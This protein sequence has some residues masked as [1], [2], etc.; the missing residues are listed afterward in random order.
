M[1]HVKLKYRNDMEQLY[2]YILLIATLP[3]IAVLAF[4]LCRC[5]RR[6]SRCQEAM[7]RLINENLEMKK[8][9]PAHECP[10]FM[11]RGDITAEEFTE[12]I[13]NM[14]KRL[15]FLSLFF[16]VAIYPMKAQE[17][18]DTTYLFR[19][20][21]DK[22]M[23]YSPWNGNGE[24]LARLLKCVDENRSAIESGQMYL[25]VTSYGTDGNAGQPATEV[26][27]VR[28]NRVKSELIMRGK[29][30][31]THFVTDRSFDAGYT[32]EN[33]KSLRN[34]V[35]VT[36]PASA[37]K[38]AEIAGEEAATK[39][40]AYNKEV[41]GE[42]ERERIAAEKAR[43][44]AGEAR[45]KAEEE[46][47][48]QEEVRIVAEK[49]EAERK[50]T[51]AEHTDAKGTTPKIQKE[52]EQYHVA[53]RANLLR[54]ATLT[55]D[56]GLEWRINSSWSI[57]ANGS[58]TSWSWNDKDRRYAIWEVIPE[59]RYYIGEQKAWYVGAMFKT[60]QFNYKLSGTGKQ[61]D[62][63]GGG[64][65]GGYQLRLNKALSMDFNLG[66]GYLNADYEKYKVIDGVRVR[67]GKESKNWWG[68][69]SA[70]VTLVW[71]IF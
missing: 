46:R 22:D 47:I 50:A 30:K 57:V 59:V 45:M 32:D 69:V 26:A 66:L 55:P 10:N 65:T 8:K 54:W 44:Q 62:L 52:P 31:E 19:F 28:R 29:V 48:R 7:V 21:A 11:N 12:I 63:M 36:L 15:M 60:G 40:E 14:L 2:L 42:A 18:Q 56:L 67:Q 53:L 51:E 9:L 4:A 24:Q 49:N 39:V 13:H 17:K 43:V 37:D 70:S 27:K 35:I 61:G 20:V 64:I 25:L 58:W 71:T 68:P 34:I 5:R 23:F 38:V 16:L 6:L 3:V 41:S 1:L 33:G